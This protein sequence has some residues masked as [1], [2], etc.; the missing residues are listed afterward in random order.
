M[1]V[2]GKNYAPRHPADAIAAG[3]ALVPEERRTQGLILKDSID[4]NISI[5]NLKKL[6]VTPN[7]FLLAPK[8]SAAQAEAVVKRLGIKTPSVKTAVINLSGGNQQKV[9]IGKWLTREMKVLIF[10]EPSRGVD[11]GARAEIHAKIRE[12]AA[13]GAAVIVISSD[14]EE[15][16]RVCDRVLVMSYGKIVACLNGGEITK[17]AILYNSYVQS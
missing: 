16:P 10:D 5:T 12:L 7:S 8:K 2:A 15:L 13:A 4:F 11:V 3:I 17:E 1:L 6:R 9:V 14:N